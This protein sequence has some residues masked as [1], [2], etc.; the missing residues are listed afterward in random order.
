MNLTPENKQHIDGLT[1][2]QLL[3]RIRYSPAGDLWFQGETGEYWMNR[4]AELRDANPA[5]VVAASKAVGWD[6]L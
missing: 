6:R 4:Y 2:L 5:G 1:V 3:E